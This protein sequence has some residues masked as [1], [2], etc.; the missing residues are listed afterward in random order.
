M[1]R[2]INPIFICFIGF[3]LF[4]A[5]CGNVAQR[6]KSQGYCPMK[7]GM[8][9]RYRLTVKE[10]LLGGIESEGEITVL[11]RQKLKGEWVIPC[12]STN[13]DWLGRAVT[14]YTY[15]AIDSEGIYTC[16]Y[17]PAWIANGELLNSELKMLE[18]RHYIVKY[19]F[20]V[21]MNWRCED[22]THK[23]STTVLSEETVT[24]PAGTFERCLRVKEEG[25]KLDKFQSET[26]EMQFEAVTW[27][28]PDVGSV[29]SIG[30]T[31]NLTLEKQL[32][33]IMNLFDGIGIPGVNLSLTVET[34]YE[35][36]SFAEDNPKRVSI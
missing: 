16:A 13:K 36:I 12:R 27:Y 23:S 28:A 14:G 9:W 6:G 10:P 32:A 8:T 1:K 17:Q 25:V 2:M 19:P 15:Y 31:R 3:M 33:P 30:K 18:D 35:L 11:P 4:L 20:M 21:G 22:R 34:Q 26:Y 29:K 5:G 7:E 24:V